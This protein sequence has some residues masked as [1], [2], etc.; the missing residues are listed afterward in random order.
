MG[1]VR[2]LQIHL[3]LSVLAVL[4]AAAVWPPAGRGEGGSSFRELPS[5]EAARRP[6]QAARVRG[7]VGNVFGDPV[8]GAQVTIGTSQALT[9]AEGRF[10]LE[11]LAPGPGKLWVRAAGF[12]PLSLEVAMDAG[13]NIIDLKYERGLWPEGFAADFHVFLAPVAGG[14]WRLFGQVGLANGSSAAVYLLAAWVEDPFGQLVVDLLAPE[15]DWQNLPGGVVYPRRAYRFN[16]GGQPSPVPGGVYRLHLEYA[17][18]TAWRAGR[19]Q[20]L[21]LES[22]ARPDLDWN[23]H[24]EN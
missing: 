14:S 5:S 18:S 17:D 4:A 15:Q 13:E 7:F 24:T 1:I 3:L 19:S 12:H 21:V 8:S 2:K 9:D 11:G 16:L 23:P 10:Y 22:A 20:H 6:E